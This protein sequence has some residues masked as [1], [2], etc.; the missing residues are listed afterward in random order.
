MEHFVITISR[1]YGSGGKQIG[2]MLAKE[3]GVEYYDQDITRFAS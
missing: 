3:L 1:G 2:I